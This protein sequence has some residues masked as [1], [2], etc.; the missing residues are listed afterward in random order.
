MNSELPNW[1]W[2]ELYDAG[3]ATMSTDQL[4]YADALWAM[5]LAMFGLT[6]HDIE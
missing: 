1:N 6:P 5:S 2:Q 3:L 4:P